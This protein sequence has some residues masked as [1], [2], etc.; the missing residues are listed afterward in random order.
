MSRLLAALAA[1]AVGAAVIA[2][3][4]VAAPLTVTPPTPISIATPFSPGCGGP[5]EGSVP[6]A[7]FNYA[8]AETEP[9]LAVSPTN[10]NDV[11][12][13]SRSAP[14]TIAEVRSRVREARAAVTTHCG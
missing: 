10:P 7:N 14:R 5:T 6:G 3:S 4:A 8:N 1:T 11:A 9:W 12:A 2:G 13:I